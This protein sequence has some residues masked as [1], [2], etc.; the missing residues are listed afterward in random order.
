MELEQK[1]KK[2][3]AYKESVRG[4]NKRR[5]TWRKQ[6][7]SGRRQVSRERSI[8]TR[9]AGPKGESCVFECPVKRIGGVILEAR[10]GGRGGREENRRT[11]ATI[12]T[13]FVHMYLVGLQ[14]S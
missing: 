1:T 3:A 6:L 2:R 5:V 10:R 12:S 9:P 4:R 13:R 8:Q 7:G 14:G 11:A